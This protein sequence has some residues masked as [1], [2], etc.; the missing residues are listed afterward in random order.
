MAGIDWAY[1]L[2]IATTLTLAVGAIYIA[3]LGM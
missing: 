1:F 3:L 2:S